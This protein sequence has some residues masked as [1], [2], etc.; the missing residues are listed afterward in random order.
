MRSVLA[1]LII[2][3]VVAAA[4]LRLAIVRSS[5]P[6]LASARAA[7]AR[8]VALAT[9]M[10]AAHFAEEYATDFHQRFPQLLGLPAMP[11]SFFVIFNLTWLAIWTLSVAG[12][13]AGNNGAFFAAWFLALAAMLNGI[14]H[15]LLAVAAGG[16]FPGVVTAPFIAAAGVVAWRRLHAATRPATAGSGG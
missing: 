2:L 13:R 3:T 16:Y 14:A 6:G 1:S 15:P 8:S 5:P 9:A 11:L 10:Q 4:A 12:I 7:A